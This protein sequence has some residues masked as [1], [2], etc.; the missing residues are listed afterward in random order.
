MVFHIINIVKMGFGTGIAVL[1]VMLWS[2]FKRF[3]SGVLAITALLLYASILIELLDGYSMLNIKRFLSYNE[4][5]IVKWILSI[6]LLISFIF[7]LVVFMKEE[8]K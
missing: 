1:A 7:T 4:M 6:L 3:S 2:R 5:P 8:K